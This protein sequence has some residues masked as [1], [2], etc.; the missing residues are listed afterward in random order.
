MGSDGRRETMQQA[1][2][3]GAEQLRQLQLSR[4]ARSLTALALKVFKQREPADTLNSIEGFR[5]DIDKIN[6]VL[7]EI[8]RRGVQAE[9]AEAVTEPFGDAWM[10]NLKRQL[11]KC[12]SQGGPDAWF[13]AW[14]DGW[15]DALAASQWQCCLEIAALTGADADLQGTQTQLAVIANDLQAGQP[16]RGLPA[17][18]KILAGRGLPAK[19]ATRLRVLRSRVLRQVL[20]DMAGAVW[21]AEEATRLSV[22]ADPPTRAL[23]QVARAEA[24]QDDKRFA[25]AHR[26]LDE[27]FADVVI[28]D[29][30]VA[31]GRLATAE[32]NFSRANEFYDAAAERFGAELAERHLLREIPGN[33]LWRTARQVAKTDQEAALRLLDEA[34]EAGIEGDSAYPD[35][36]ALREKARLLEDLGRNAEAAATYRDAAERYSS[37]PDRALR[38]YEKAYTLA[39][40]QARY[41][42]EYGEALRSRTADA[43]GVVDADG[44][45]KAK[46]LLD[47]GFALASPTRDEAWALVSAALAAD[48]LQDASDPTVLIERAILLNPGYARGYA[49]LAALLQDRGFVTEAAEAARQGYNAVAGDSLTTAQ[50]AQALA[51][52]GRY[53]EALTILDHYLALQPIVPDLVLVKSVMHLRLEEYDNALA[54]LDRMDL[55]AETVHFSRGICYSAAGREADERRCFE[56]VWRDRG[57]SDRLSWTGWAAYR[58]GLLDES[59]RVLS[60]LIAKGSTT[61]SSHLDLGQVRLVRGNEAENDL[62][63]G[64]QTLRETIEKA[65]RIDDLVQLT[66][67]DFRLARKAVRGR[68][69]EQRALAVLDEAQRQ[70]DDRCAQLRTLVRPASQLAARLARGRLAI[71]A[72]NFDEALPIYLDLARAADPPEAVFGLRA[73]ANG[74]L[75]QGDQ[76][77]AEGDLGMARA[78][79]DGLAAATTVLGADDTF[80]R[81]LRARSGLSLL[82]L[83]G[84]ADHDAF[85]LLQDCDGR[86]LSEAVQHFARNVPSLWQHREGLRAIATR[87]GLRPAQRETLMSCSQDLPFDRIYSLGRHAV[88]YQAVFPL[89]AAV[90]LALG[91]HHID[92]IKSD[93]L[94]Q[95]IPALRER[96]AA[97]TGVRI[98]GIRVYRQEHLPPAT[99]Q[100]L[101]YEQAV[102]ELGVPAGVHDQAGIILSRFDQVLRENLF[103]LI[104]VDEVDLWAAGW[105][106]LTPDQPVAYPSWGPS[107]AP[108]RLRLARLL[109]MLLREGVAVND[110]HK[111]LDAFRSAETS[112]GTGPLETLAAV[113]SCL[114]PAILGPDPSAPVWPVPSDL[115]ARMLA[116]LDPELAKWELPRDTAADLLHDL[117]SWRARD[118]PPGSVTLSL[119]EGRIRPFLWRLLAADRPIMYIVA[120]EE[121]P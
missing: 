48:S 102:A 55:D 87:T 76:R 85:S 50:H 19:A 41:R 108:A 33:L 120:Q 37:S 2:N 57:E 24:Y 10:S 54:A 67:V 15:S 81:A 119:G 94:R 88:S 98:P 4:P 25:D 38:L 59:V 83:N 90:E 97:E 23:A 71:G 45:R 95:G 43:D 47:E 68:P 7:G 105:E 100:F 118:L 63:A 1:L 116:G 107:D 6:E 75:G 42:W 32:G 28:P 114:Y 9:Q 78:Y 13:A 16:E 22:D 40:Q 20:S 96:L 91:R 110:R 103:R 17:V 74:L 80:T 73:A 39:P 70:A 115:E 30:F 44:L 64:A 104:T 66:T 106:V 21:S 51:D 18:T 62:S 86:S 3:E 14:L 113:R 27:T 92:L 82:E 34:I 93:G 117:R 111:I 31:A 12:A 69:H 99:V 46:A 89:V 61:Q 65:T 60:E 26:L 112:S 79:W 121:L 8:Y 109:R 5:R 56:A 53:R 84:P 11:D 52:L 58:L 29:L 49:F 101:V 77:L 72:G 36:R 35:R